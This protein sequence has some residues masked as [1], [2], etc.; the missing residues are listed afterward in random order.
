MPLVRECAHDDCSVLTMGEY[1]LEHEQEMEAL[2]APLADEAAA[3]AA[4]E[5]ESSVLVD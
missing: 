4:Q 3:L 2:D 5:Q 1:C